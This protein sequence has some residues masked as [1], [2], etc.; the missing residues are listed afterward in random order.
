MVRE[1]LISPKAKQDNL[2]LD[3]RELLLFY[4]AHKID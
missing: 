2:K 4:V 1:M 3:F